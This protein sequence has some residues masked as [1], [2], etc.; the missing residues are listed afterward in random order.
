M[1]SEDLKHPELILNRYRVNLLN[2]LKLTSIMIICRGILFIIYILFM[3]IKLLL[4]FD[5]AFI[6]LF[7][8]M[9]IIYGI[10]MFIFSYYM[11]P[12]MLD[13]I[14]ALNNISILK[15]KPLYLSKI[16]ETI[17]LLYKSLQ[18]EKK[19]IKNLQVKQDSSLFIR[20]FEEKIKQEKYILWILIMGLFFEITIIWFDGITIKNIIYIIVS[21]LLIIISL[22]ITKYSK[23]WS[24][25]YSNLSH[26]NKFF[27]NYEITPKKKELNLL[28]RDFQQ[29][30]IK[31]SNQGVKCPVCGM[32]NDP[33]SKYC[34]NCGNELKNRWDRK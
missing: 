28:E 22:K 12:Q 4:N 20:Y 32:Y 10:V 1:N 26:W 3:I 16:T 31:N 24:D 27:S 23:S 30:E 33:I 21:S 34:D 19:K 13:C 18:S 15:E 14:V 7:I 17:F 5:P 6:I 29:F 2:K 25:S 9:G 11:I 8:F